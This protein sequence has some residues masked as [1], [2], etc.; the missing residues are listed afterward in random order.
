MEDILQKLTAPFGVSGFEGAVSDCFA[1]L[2]SPFGDVRCDALGNVF[3]H[4]KGGGKRLLIEAHMDEVGLMVTAIHGGFLSFCPI[5]G[6]DPKILPGSTVTVLG[7]CEVAGVIGLK[8]PHLQK[9]GEER[10]LAIEAM[11]ID[12]GLRD[13]SRL[14]SVGDAVVFNAPSGRVGSLFCARNLDNRA[15]LAVLLRAASLIKESDFDIT[16]CAT[17]GEESGLRGAYAVGAAASYDV[18]ISLDTTFGSSEGVEGY[19]LGDGPTVCISPTLSVP[20]S[21]ALLSFGAS[22]GIPLQI[23]TEPG[24][25]GT[26]AY[27]IAHRVPQAKC[28]LISVPIRYMHTTCEMAALS[29]M[30]HAAALVSAF[31]QKGASLC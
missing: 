31:A 1:A 6:I 22:E 23:E 5:G 28:L 14:V 13:A 26:N 2:A 18:A 3:C 9:A 10:R 19:P 11:S 25:T 24:N 20:L 16:Y 15:S 12:T 30:E 27:A 8:P 29:D 17:I 21:R 4:R 7:K